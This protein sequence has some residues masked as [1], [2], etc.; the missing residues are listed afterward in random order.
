MVD[1]SI[2]RGTTCATYY[3]DVKESRSKGGTCKD[4]L[5]AVPYIRVISELMCRPMNS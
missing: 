1:D 4:Q 5:T 2:V 3:P